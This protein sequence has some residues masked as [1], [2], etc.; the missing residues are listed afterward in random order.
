M[1]KKTADELAK[2][3]QKFDTNGD[4]KISGEELRQ[5]LKSLGT[6]A[7]AE[8]V[9]KMMAEI[10]K[11]GDGQIDLAEFREFHGDSSQGSSNKELREAFAM[12]DKDGNGLISATELQAVL[13]CLGQTCSLEDCVR[14]I[15]CVDVDGDLHVNFQ[16]FIKM[17][18]V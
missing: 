15:Q 4:G 12:Y 17:M 8:E 9:T 13:K 6:E 14:M 18:S 1:S 3:F 5:M 2:V 7:T 16:E 11:D 10:D